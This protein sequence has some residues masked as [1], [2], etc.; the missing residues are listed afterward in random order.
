MAPKPANLRQ[1][2]L[3]RLLA[4]AKQASGVELHSLPSSEV[5]GL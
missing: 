1:S 2:P 5:H 3:Q 4:Q